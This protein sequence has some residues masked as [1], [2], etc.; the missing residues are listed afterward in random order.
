[1]VQNPPEVDHS[2]GTHLLESEG[3]RELHLVVQR[4]GLDK[5]VSKKVQVLQA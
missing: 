3:E 5:G 2:S 4:V 1:M